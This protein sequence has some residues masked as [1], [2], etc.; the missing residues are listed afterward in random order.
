MFNEKPP[1]LLALNV[2]ELKAGAAGG[3]SVPLLHATGGMGVLST[4]SPQSDMLEFTWTMSKELDLGVE[5]REFSSEAPT[6]PSS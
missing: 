3:P 4:S 6:S 5:V 2:G 1:E